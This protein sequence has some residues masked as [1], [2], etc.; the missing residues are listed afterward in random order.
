MRS[1]QAAALRICGVNICLGNPRHPPALLSCISLE[2]RPLNEFPLLRISGQDYLN[3]FV[4]L[5]GH[6]RA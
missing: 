2:G 3:V 5:F 4:P 6:L 1:A